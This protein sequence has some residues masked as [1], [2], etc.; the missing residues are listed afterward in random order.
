MAARYPN[1]RTPDQPTRYSDLSHRERQV[2]GQQFRDFGRELDQGRLAGEADQLA[3][4]KQGVQSSAKQARLRAAS[5][6]VQPGPVTV[7]QAARNRVELIEQGTRENARLPGEGVIPGAA[8]YFDAARE[9][10]EIAPNITPRQRAVSASVM[11]PGSD[12]GAEQ[13]GLRALHDAQGAEVEGRKF[14]DVPG[15]EIPEMLQPPRP[16]AED[17]DWTGLATPFD[18]RTVGRAHDIIRGEA[19]AA[20]ALPPQSA[21]KTWS[22]AEGKT[23]AGEDLGGE[24]EGEYRRRAGVLGDKISGT[25]GEGQTSMDLYGLAD[26]R[27]GILDPEGHTAEDTWMQSINVRHK[28]TPGAGTAKAAG[29]I[30][31]QQGKSRERVVDRTYS[32]E[33]EKALAQTEA[34]RVR[35]VADE[36]GGRTRISETIADRDPSVSAENLR[37]ATSHAATV[38]AGRMLG[39]R[40]ETHHPEDPG[41][42]SVPSV[43]VQETAWTAQK[44][45]EPKRIG[46]DPSVASSDSEYNQYRASQ[47]PNPRA[48]GRVLP[49]STKW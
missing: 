13:A 9:E 45:N 10:A 30:S 25:V 40:Y 36:P 43:L 8:W 28:F 24:V 44:R 5:A 16:D 47:Q 34:P 42:F 37:H 15:R 46:L 31:Y 32:P 20:Q 19:D 33:E 29:D 39:D 21:P 7:S 3:S 41:G 23:L 27:E 49:G 12:P 11:S 38:E 2:T 1:P 4:R 22:Y 6:D 17:V 48:R 18:A 35:K 26:S 14:S